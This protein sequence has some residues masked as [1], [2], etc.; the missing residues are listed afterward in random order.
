MCNRTVFYYKGIAF[1][2]KMADVS[3]IG[4]VLFFAWSPSRF[5]AKSRDSSFLLSSFP[6]I[7]PL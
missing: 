7:F 5:V 3:S 6:V 4:S 1:N 2:L